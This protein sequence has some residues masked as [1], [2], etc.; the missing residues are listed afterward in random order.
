MSDA[1]QVIKCSACGTSNPASAEE[2]SNCGEP[3]A[4]MEPE[5]LPNP[6]SRKAVAVPE[7][8]GAST[9]RVTGRRITGRTRKVGVLGFSGAG[10]S[11]YLSML[12]HATAESTAFAEDWRAQWISGDGGETAR[13]LKGLSQQIRGVDGMGKTIYLDKS[14]TEVNRRW[15]I[16]TSKQQHLIFSLIKQAGIADVRLDVETLDI[17]GEVLQRAV[18]EG[19]EQLPPDYRSRWDE[20]EK[21]CLQSDGLMVFL[22]MY[23]EEGRQ[24]AGNLRLL[25]EL[26][27]QYGVLPKSVA[28]VTVGADLL[29]TAEQREQALQEVKARY[30][31][32]REIL[33]SEGIR[34]E[35]FLVSSIGQGMTSK[36]NDGLAPECADPS[37]ICAQCQTLV[38]TP[39][40][41]PSPINLAQPWDFMLECFTPP[42]LRIAFVTQ[43]VWI[44]QVLQQRLLRPIPFVVLALLLPVLLLWREYHQVTQHRDT[45]HSVAE[46]GYPDETLAAYQHAAG[47]LGTSWLGKFYA[48]DSVVD[49][50]QLAEIQRY[51]T[52][53]QLLDERQHPPLARFSAL[54]D[55]INAENNASFRDRVDA[56]AEAEHILSEAISDRSVPIAD[57]LRLAVDVENKATAIVIPPEAVAPSTGRL[58]AEIYE[59]ANRENQA[60]STAG[61]LINTDPSMIANHYQTAGEHLRNLIALATRHELNEQTIEAVRKLAHS[62]AVAQDLAPLIR[63]QPHTLSGAF[64]QIEELRHYQTQYADHPLARYAK[65]KIDELTGLAEK[66]ERE[67]WA[68][69]I[70]PL[71]QSGEE[72][73]RIDP[74]AGIL[75]REQFL[76]KWNDPQAT[77]LVRREL[78]LLKSLAR[79]RAAWLELDLLARDLGNQHNRDRALRL[80]NNFLQQFPNSLLTPNARS[81]VERIE[82]VNSRRNSA[83]QAAFMALPPVPSNAREWI[84]TDLDNGILLRQSFLTNWQDSPLAS[85]V[86]TDIARLQEV[87][88]HK[89]VWLRLTAVNQPLDSSAARDAALDEL[90]A[91]IAAQPQSPLRSE[92]ESLIGKIRRW[93]PTP[94]NYSVSRITTADNSNDLRIDLIVT[95]LT[96][97]EPTVLLSAFPILANYG[98]RE[99]QLLEIDHMWYAVHPLHI[100]ARIFD[101][102]TTEFS[103]P[104]HLT[105]NHDD[106]PQA[107]RQPLTLGGVT[108]YLT[109]NNK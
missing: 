40:A 79:Q 53:R 38:K 4:Y 5:P 10:K 69:K 101:R 95:E 71:P 30:Q 86:L 26:L 73:L 108:L 89:E 12:Y 106:Y 15:P 105:I 54:S 3:I 57:R 96:P 76:D 45:I 77:I 84:E 2:C 48:V 46:A 1:G 6:P 80:A 58:L 91:F 68:A 64:S 7:R 100:T 21:L 47:A 35:F 43:L 41:Q 74:Q 39:S 85:H 27:L 83:M 107:F 75:A 25:L 17:S 98:K 63:A 70:P 109:P 28:F 104:W 51:L 99:S 29:L 88:P 19:V 24:D 37:H 93:Q 56:V 67:E 14:R 66:L 9:P 90:A 82:A 55:Y 52:L 62:I 42:L 65:N 8:R 78:T 13:Y 81:V 103:E 59:W 34:S 20:V 11:V 22:G 102:T 23:S 50:A 16:G 94:L 49:S 87:K 31:R 36:K 72:L 97:G 61:Y 60:V 33:E 32:S 18:A 92:A 44:A